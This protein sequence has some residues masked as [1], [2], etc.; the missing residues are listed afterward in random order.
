MAVRVSEFAPLVLAVAYVLMCP[1]TKVEESFNMQATHDLLFHGT[2]L[3]S[4]RR[5]PHG[6]SSRPC[7][8]SVGCMEAAARRSSVSR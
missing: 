5:R 4:V 1:Y 2:D 6:G 3:D 7:H 8:P